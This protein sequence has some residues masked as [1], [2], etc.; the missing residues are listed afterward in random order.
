MKLNKKCKIESIAS[1]DSTRHVLMAPYLEVKAGNG[2]LIATNGQGLVV[3][4]VE[5]SESD[6]SGH[7]P[8]TALKESRKGKVT[9]PILE[10]SEKAILLQDG[11]S[12][13]RADLGNFPNWRQIIP[14]Q[15]GKTL[16]RVALNAEMLHAI[17]S[18]MGTA[19]VI[20][21]FDAGNFDGAPIKVFPTSS[22]KYGVDAPASHDAFGVIMPIRLS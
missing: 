20:L 5:V 1:K 15:E 9:E 3:I 10:C 6:V 19:G 13:Q 7:I 21:E 17:A 14:D 2:N 12:F 11:T 8:L 22:G 16:R 4:P 18:A